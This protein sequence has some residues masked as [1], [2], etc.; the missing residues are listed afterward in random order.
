MPAFMA[1][2]MPFCTNIS[3]KGHARSC[4]ANS[5]G[6]GMLTRRWVPHGY[7]IDD[8][9]GYDNGCE[10]DESVLIASPNLMLFS[11]SKRPRHTTLRLSYF[12]W[13]L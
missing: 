2:R 13:L 8:D 12:T 5:P 6:P 1:C 9:N 10:N 11:Q 7:V 3:G 4:W